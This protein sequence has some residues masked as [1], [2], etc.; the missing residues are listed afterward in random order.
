VDALLKMANVPWRDLRWGYQFFGESLISRARSITATSFLENDLGDIL[1]YIDDDI[2]FSPS[3]VH[4]I[5][6]DVLKYQTIVCAPYMIKSIVQRRL[7]VTYLNA[8]P[9]LVGPGGKVQEVKYAS[10]G[11]FAIPKKV[12]E[13][14]TKILPRLNTGHG[15]KE[16]GT[17]QVAMYPFFNPGWREDEMI[18]LS[19]D[20][21]MCD[22]ARR[23]GYRIL[24]DSSIVLKHIGEVE[25]YGGEAFDR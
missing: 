20:Y 5:V 11:F 7:A 16:D 4:Q 12:L 19:E 10:T 23:L 17:P 8:D 25:Y 2:I 15:L 1:L 13:D 22:M 6:D 3:N 24:L 14:M 18:Y 9:I 21:F